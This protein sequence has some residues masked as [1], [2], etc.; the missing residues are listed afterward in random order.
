MEVDDDG[1]VHHLLPP[2]SIKMMGEAVGVSSLN[3]DAALR[4]SEDLE[5]RLKEIVQD[6]IKFSRNSKRKI[7]LTSDVDHA[8]SVK[9][10]EPLYGF[11]CADYVPFRHTSGGGKDLFYPDE[12]EID[13]LDLI[14]SPLPRLPCDVTL[15]PHWLAVEGVQPLIPENPPPLTA[16]EQYRE[17]LGISMPRESDLSLH[18]REVKF[19]RKSKKKEETTGVADWSKLKP[20]HAHM[21]SMEQ[22]LYYKELTEACIG[23]LEQ[24][25]QEA[26]N[27]LSTDPGVYQ[28]LPQ[29]TN[30]V[31]EG[32]KINIAQRKL[33]MLKHLLKM[34]NSLL[35]N[36]SVSVERYLHE[37]LP[38]VM[39][40]LINKQLCLR[41]ENDDH[42]SVRDMAAKLVAIICKKYGNSVNNVQSRV[43]RVLSMSLSNNTQGLAVHYGAMAGLIELGQ[44]AVTNLVIPRLKQEG[45]VIR[46]VMSTAG[47][48]TEQV[49]ANRLQSLLLRHCSLIL[50]NSRPTSDTLQMYQND[51]G[52]LG[53]HLFN[54]VKSL[55]QNKQAVGKVQQGTST[56]KSP[57]SPTV[58]VQPS[59][60][61]RPPHFTLVPAKTPTTP[62]SSKSFTM[63]SPTIAAA[64]RFIT[65]H[66]STTSSSSA[67]SPLTSPVTTIPSNLLSVVIS[68]PTAQAALVSHLNNSAASVAASSSSNPSSPTV[69]SVSAGTNTTAAVGTS[70]NSTGGTPNPSPVTAQQEVQPSDK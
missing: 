58:T 4:M 16:D 61:H 52:Y 56:L 50:W 44:D 60:S 48:T 13:L 38:V 55:R 21:L 49:A 64:L 45:E 37:L 23:T 3:E 51:Y 39:T 66:Q 53:Q 41:P 32:I 40:C 26:L 34:I 18:S 7:L 20:L 1:P 46:I 59:G 27:S 28:L 17:A 9:N 15:R 68:S 54:Q 62:T 47:K 69:T 25:R 31:V 2:E 19:D 30:F 11:D 29:L 63:T 42:W 12:K 24:K 70:T 8:L 10:I 6:A 57:T 22:Q 33:P 36:A 43:T 35:S 14:N 67:G 5:Y 65:Q